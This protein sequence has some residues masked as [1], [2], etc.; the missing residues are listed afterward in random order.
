MNI[1]RRPIPR[2]TKYLVAGAIVTYIIA[3]LALSAT[4]AVSGATPRPT[5]PREV[6]AVTRTVI[7]PPAYAYRGRTLVKTY[8]QFGSDPNS[9]GR[10]GYSGHLNHIGFPFRAAS[11]LAIGAA[12]KS[13]TPPSISRIQRGLP[14]EGTALRTWNAVFPYRSALTYDD[15]CLPL[16]LLPLGFVADTTIYALALFGLMRLLRQLRDRRRAGRD[17]CTKCK[18]PLGVMNTCPECGSPAPQ[19]PSSAALRGPPR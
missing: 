7:P 9:D 8:W 5:V 14:I 10:S 18:Y 19:R 4:P 2:V 16:R 1:A 13:G 6:R 11:V 17:L 12:S 15:P 3:F